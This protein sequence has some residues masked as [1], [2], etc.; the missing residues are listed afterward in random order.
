MNELQL[1]DDAIAIALA[2]LDID[3]AITAELAK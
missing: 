3:D 2:K 1:I